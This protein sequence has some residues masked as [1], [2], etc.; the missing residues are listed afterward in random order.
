LFLGHN[1]QTTNARK[2]TKGS[3]DAHL[4]LALFLKRNKKLLLGVGAHGPM[5]VGQ[6]KA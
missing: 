3:E 6:I 4:R 1:V 5:S 2:P